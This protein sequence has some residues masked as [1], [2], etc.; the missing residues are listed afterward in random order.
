[1]SMKMSSIVPP[2]AV[3]LKV[4]N[5]QNLSYSISFFQFQVSISTVSIAN[6]PSLL[7]TLVLG[8]TLDSCN[9]K[10]IYSW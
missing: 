6:C 2:I 9:N 4:L 3:C 10:D 1:M 5:R 8:S 7:L